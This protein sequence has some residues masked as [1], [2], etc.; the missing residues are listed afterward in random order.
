MTTGAGSILAMESLKRIIDAGA[1]FGVAPTLDLELVDY[2]SGRNFL[3]VPG[4]ATPSELNGALK[5]CSIIKTFPTAQL[6]DPEYLRALSA[7]FA[8]MYTRQFRLILQ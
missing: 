1:V 3:F 4:I 8:L 6:G 5:K 7:P 2:A